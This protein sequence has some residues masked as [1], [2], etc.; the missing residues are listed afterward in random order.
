MAEWHHQLHGHEFELVQG[1]GDGQR[2]L[3]CCSPWSFKELDMAELLNCTE[4]S[5]G[6]PDTC[7]NENLMYFKIYMSV[8]R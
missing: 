2:S 6:R 7:E 8:N 1:I 4:C 3:A 5:F